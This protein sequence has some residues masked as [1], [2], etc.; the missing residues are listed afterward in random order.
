M[1]YTTN[2][3]LIGLHEAVAALEPHGEAA[4]YAA[5][6]DALAGFLVRIQSRAPPQSP[7]GAARPELEGAYFRAWDFEKWEAWGS[8]ADL[9]WGA[10][11]IETGWTMPWIATSFALRQLRTSLWDT[12]SSVDAAADF[13]SWLP[14]FFPEGDFS[15]VKG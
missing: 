10:W 13:A 14:F 7:A 6:E 12:A 15:D 2:F 5:A 4:P 3:A 8:D 11:S 1:L 9:G